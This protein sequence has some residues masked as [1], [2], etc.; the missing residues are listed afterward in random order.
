MLTTVSRRIPICVVLSISCLLLAACSEGNHSA[1]NHQRASSKQGSVIVSDQ[2]NYMSSAATWEN[3]EKRFD[4]P[5]QQQAPA[6]TPATAFA[7]CQCSEYA[8]YS[9]PQISYGLYTDYVEG[10]P[11]P[12]GHLS[13]KHVRQPAWFILFTNVP[14]AFSGGAGPPGSSSDLVTQGDV[15]TVVA[16]STGKSIVQMMGMPDPTAEP[17]PPSASE[18]PAQ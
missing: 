10:T 5:G 1:T 7:D 6:L 9:Q 14:I 2:V 4:P 8:Q 15:L 3:G 16:D 17:A 11:L 13:L 12:D 18:Q